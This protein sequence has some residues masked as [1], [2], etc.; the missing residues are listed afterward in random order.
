MT[1]TVVA[2]DGTTSSD[3]TTVN[4]AGLPITATGTSISLNEGDEYVAPLAT[5]TDTSPTVRDAAYYTATITFGDD[6]TSV[7]GTIVADPN[8]GYDVEDTSGHTY[9]GGSYQDTITISKPGYVATTSASFAV[10]DSPLTSQGFSLVT[11]PAAQPFTGQSPVE[12]QPYTGILAEFNDADPRHPPAS[13]YYA[14]IDY[15]D[16]SAPVVGKIVPDPN[17]DG[18]TWAVE[19]DF[20]FG[21][22]LRR[23]H[24]DRQLLGRQHDGRLHDG[25]RH[26][27]AALGPVLQLHPR[28]R[29]DLH[30]IR[31]LV[32]HRRPA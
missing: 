27:R 15:G 17:G 11:Q 6:H 2:I 7:T 13:N 21:A 32:H 14:T 10:K 12:G 20:A 4:V 1:V 29:P 9:D 23:D 25:R 5:F 19:G 3:T 22:A 16:G 18:Y 31:G 24:D 8:G 28:R 30:R 26:A